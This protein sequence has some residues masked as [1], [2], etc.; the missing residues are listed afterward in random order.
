[1][2]ESLDILANKMSYEVPVQDVSFSFHDLPS[3]PHSRIVIRKVKAL[4]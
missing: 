4:L 2:K 3:L 1:M